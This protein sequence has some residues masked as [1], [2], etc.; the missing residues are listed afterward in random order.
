M[1]ETL[2]VT[3]TE[4]V[5]RL[6]Q[7]FNEGKTEE[8][9]N[10]LDENCEWN[11]PAPRDIVPYGGTRKGKAAI[12]EFFKLL[13]ESLE[14]KQ[15]EPR[16]FI[17]QNNRVIVLGYWE[18]RVKKTGKI[19][20]GDWAMSFTVKN[21]KISRYQGFEDTYNTVEAFRPLAGKASPQ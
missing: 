10:H 1:Q 2:I 14:V 8:L 6:Y 21:G 17:E 7:L 4:L 13:N 11:D 16:E 9:I 5:K 20:K 19:A 18:A 3:N 15:M 12:R